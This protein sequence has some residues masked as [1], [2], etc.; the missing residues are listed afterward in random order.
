M[1]K[2]LFLL[3]ISPSILVSAQETLSLNNRK[4]DGYKGIWF[5]L[6]QKY[7]FGDK[8]SGGL[9]T[10]TAKHM[11]LALYAEAVQKT[12]FVYGGTTGENERHLLCMAGEFDHRTNTVTKPTVVYDKLEVNDPHDNPSIMLDEEGYIWVFVS[13]RGSLREGIKLRSEKPY[14]IESFIEMS[15]ETF[16]YPQIWNTGKGYFHFFT[17]YT[18]TRELYFETSTDGNSWSGDV[19]LAGIRENPGEKGGHY[20]VSGHYQKGTI[21]GTFFNRHRDGHPDTRTD[22]YYIQTKDFGKTWENIE[23]KK[24]SLP[25]M[26]V[27]VGERVTDYFTQGKNVYMKDMGYDKNGHPVCLYITSGGHEPGPD[28]A[29]YEWRITRWDGNKWITSV[30]CESDHNYDMGSLFL[31]DTT[32]T[33]VAPTLTGPQAWGAGGEIALWQSVNLGKDWTM[34]RQLTKGSPMNHGYV[35]RP[36]NARAPFSFFWASGDPHHFSRSKLYFGDFEGNV[37]ELPYVMNESSRLPVKVE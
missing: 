28:N 12:F 21:I 37:W 26:E 18:G 3:L 5:E 25:L 2:L 16:T 33:I 17:K 27:T 6:N 24:S 34:I 14:S 7:P 31:S 22:L 11:P 15:V 9:G 35:R 13:G 36:L 23:G 19:K 20:Q 4:I 29:P 1:N 30:I 8:Y 10:Y 32:W